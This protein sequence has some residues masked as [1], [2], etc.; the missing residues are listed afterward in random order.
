MKK[1]TNCLWILML[2]LILSAKMRAAD[3]YLLTPETVN[4]TVGKNE[5]PSNHQLLPNTAYGSNVYSLKITSMP[6]RDFRSVLAC[7]DGEAK[8]SHI[9]T[10][11]LL[12]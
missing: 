5:V 12:L 4:G 3:V 2:L 6:K 9:P 7:R 10:T 11:P 1:S 8:C